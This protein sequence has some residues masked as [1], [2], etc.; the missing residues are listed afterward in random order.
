MRTI[1]LIFS[2]VLVVVLSSCSNPDQKGFEIVKG[3]IE[4]GSQGTRLEGRKVEV[5]KIGKDEVFSDFISTEDSLVFK[6]DGAIDTDKKLYLK[7]FF[8]PAGYLYKVEILPRKIE[9]NADLIKYLDGKFEK[10]QTHRNTWFLEK[11]NQHKTF[12]V[13]TD[14]SQPFKVEYNYEMEFY[15]DEK[16]LGKVPDFNFVREFI[17]DFRSGQLTVPAGKI[18]HIYQKSF[19]LELPSDIEKGEE[20]YCSCPGVLNTR[21]QERE[22]PELVINK[23]CIQAKGRSGD[24][25]NFQIGF[26]LDENSTLNIAKPIATNYY[27]KVQEYSL[28]ESKKEV[29]QKMID[30]KLK[31]NTPWGQFINR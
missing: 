19:D 11:G 28:P 14:K 26:T 17:V 27:F 21:T 18:W 23:K 12:V 10:S 24:L 3:I 25:M 22:Y 8:S 15:Q 31:Y 16:E 30:R 6:R 9:F 29:Y 2:L 20:K 5:L 1:C 13:P 7:Y 4:R